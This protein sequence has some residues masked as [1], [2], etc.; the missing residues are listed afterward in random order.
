MT[1]STVSPQ[2][3][4]I[5]VKLKDLGDLLAATPHLIGFRPAESVILISHRG[6]RGD[7]IGRVLR[8][9]LPPR[10][11]VFDQA[12]HLAKVFAR[13]DDF[14][15]TLVIVGERRD[16]PEDF[17]HTELVDTLGALL[18]E[19]G[20]DKVHALWAPEIATGAPW[21]CYHD[22][23]C[24]GV[25]PEVHYSELAA[26]QASVG[27]VT[28]D[29]REAMERTLAPADEAAIGRR[30]ALLNAVYDEFGPPDESGEAAEAGRRVVRTALGQVKRDTFDLTD[31]QAVELA[32][33]LSN[34]RVRDAGLALAVVP[35]SDEAKIAE[36]LWLALVR[37]LP[38][39]ERAEAATLL[40]YSAFLRHD[41]VMAGM[42]FE[43]A[44]TADPNH[45]LA[46][47]LRA[48]MEH[49]VRPEQMTGLGRAE[50]SASLAESAGD[51]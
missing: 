24:G 4:Q 19:A 44:L 39:P 38:E 14:G 35:E 16:G 40:G 20:V 1:T 22:T 51:G 36:R 32:V 12:R 9:D 3:G 8:A 18:T 29:S 7:F 21:E 6:P 26:A 50:G 42:A 2:P 13:Q 27:T 31:E 25:L 37:G 49:Q 15:V 23:G 10:P 28:F 47:L 43:N 33:A 41:T 30:S 17:V 46:A 45:M 48:A 5:R 34:P 11:L